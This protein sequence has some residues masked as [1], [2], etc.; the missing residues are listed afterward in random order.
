MNLKHHTTSTG[1]LILTILSLAA[2]GAARRLAQDA[3]AA[4][5]G[6]FIAQQARRQGGE[7]YEEARKIV[8]G[9]LVPETVVLY[10]I[11]GQGGSNNYIQYLAVFTRRRGR[12]Q[13]LAQAR[14]GGK[15]ARSVE[16]SSV[17]KKTITLG[18]LSYAPK[19]ASCCPSIKGTT[20]YVLAGQALRERRATSRQKPRA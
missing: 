13:A 3:D 5:I 10:T 20:S 16:L 9:D 1:V 14:V 11:E 8:A 17:D 12:L 19:D 7:E 6:S 2:Y 18:T 15:S 4:V